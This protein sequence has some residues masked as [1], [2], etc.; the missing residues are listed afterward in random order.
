MLFGWKH[1]SQE[2]EERIARGIV[3]NTTYGG[4]WALEIQP[5]DRCNVDCFFCGTQFLRTDDF[6]PWER[7]KNL[8]IDGARNDLRFLRLSGGGE[9][10]FYPS[11]RPM[12]DTC[13]ELKLRLANL[14]TNAVLLE[15]LAH[16]ILEIG[17]DYL[18]VSLNESDPARYA[19]TMRTSP[20]AFDH[21]IRGIQT[22]C[23]MRNSLPLEKRPQVELQFL[24]W[25]QNWR[26]LKE[27]YEF[28]LSLPVDHIVFRTIQHLPEGDR[29]PAEEIPS[30]KALLTELIEEDSRDGQFKIYFDLATE[31][32]LHQ[33]AYMKQSKLCPPEKKRGPDFIET[34]PR[35]EYCYTAWFSAMIN[36]QGNVFPCSDVAGFPDRVMGNILRQSLEEIWQGP[37]FQ[38]LR[39]EI[40]QLMLLEGKVDHNNTDFHCLAPRCI[41][42]FSCAWSFFLCSPQFYKETI[43]RARK[44]F[45]LFER[46]QSRTRYSI[47]RTI[48][49]AEQWVR[50]TKH[51]PVSK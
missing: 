11:I 21:A 2:E 7:L 39:N 10:L 32:D 42:P 43:T 31:A 49:R 6:L 16:Q 41:D 25:K 50:R 30:V 4:P 5:T 1:L 14:T 20:R 9:S 46:A 3:E 33:F 13:G 23:E 38:R 37:G 17:L 18:M 28:G 36:A 19:E 47:S 24:V 29:I 40:R 51:K 45:S 27:M 8:L 34:H 26:F 15:P 35:Q 22:I 44:N 48:K 12:L